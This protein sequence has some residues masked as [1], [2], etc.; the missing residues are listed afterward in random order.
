MMFEV[1]HLT[2]VFSLAVWV[3]TMLVYGA[4][5]VSVWVLTMLVYGC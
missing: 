4:N 1:A 2:S 5:H 3:L